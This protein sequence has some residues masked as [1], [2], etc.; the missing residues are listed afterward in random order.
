VIRVL[1]AGGNVAVVMSPKIY[2]ASVANPTHTYSAWAPQTITVD[3]DEHDFRP[4]DPKGCIVALKAKGDA[5][6]D[7][8][9]F[10]LA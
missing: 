3:G 9:G 7:T 5:R 2:K 6:K 1:R 10:V 4:A 8:S